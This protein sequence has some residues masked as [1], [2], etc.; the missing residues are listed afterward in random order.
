MLW[1]G[2]YPNQ[3]D[4]FVEE[5]AITSGYLAAMQTP[6]LKGRSFTADEDTP[7]PHAVVIVHPAF[8]N[9]FFARADPIGQ[10]LRINTD[11]PWSTVV[12][13]AKD[14]RNESLETAAGPAD[15][16]SLPR[17]QRGA[18][19]NLRRC[20]P[21][22]AA[23]LRCSRNPRPFAQSIP[24]SPSLALGSTRTGIVRLVLREGL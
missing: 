1:V 5:R 6:L 20:A 13:V 15:L 24:A 12:G 23:E 3:N 19:R 16:R 8:A 14:I 17:R 7:G 2:G 18:Q 21:L 4:Q 11:R 10:H 22:N 9:K